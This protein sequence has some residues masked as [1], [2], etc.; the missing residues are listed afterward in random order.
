MIVHEK[1]RQLSWVLLTLLS[2]YRRH[3]GQTAFMTIGLLTGVALWSSVQLINDHARASYGEADQL[4]GAESAYWV[5]NPGGEGI[6]VEDY[7]SL[8]L[9]GFTE[10]YPVVESRVLT[11]SGKVIPIV[12]TDLLALPLDAYGSADTASSPLAGSSWLSFIQPA[13]QSWYSAELAERLNIAPGEEVEL[14]NGRKM[15]PAL[16][17]SRSQQG[18]RVFMDIAAA[19]S[20][21]ADE[22]FSYLAVTSLD[23]AKRAKLEAALPSGLKL[24][25]NEQVLDLTQL[26]ESLHTHLTAMGLLSFAVG[27]FIVFNA[28]RFSLLARQGTFNTLR[29]M[30]A[31]VHLIGTAI[32]LETIV[33]SLIGTAGGLIAG[34]L[35]SGILLPTVAGTLQSLY[36]AIVESDIEL[37]LRQMFLAWLMT[38]LGLVLALAGPLWSRLKISVIEGRSSSL[39]WQQDKRARN[40]MMWCA[41]PLVVLAIGGYFLIETVVDGFVVLSLILFSSAL[42]LPALIQ[43]VNSLFLNRLSRFNWKLRWAASDAFAQLPQLRVALMALLLTLT[44]NIGVTTLVHSFRDALSNWLEVRLSADIYLQRAP[45]QV[46]MLSSVENMQWLVANHNRSG[47]STRWLNRPA[48]VQG[49]DVN[50]PAILGMQLPEQMPHGFERWTSDTTEPQPVLANEQVKHLGKVALGDIVYLDSAKG[51]FS[52]E[53]VGFFHD[54]GTPYYRFYLPKPI[55]EQRWQSVRSEGLALWV[56]PGKLEAAEQALMDAGAEPGEWIRQADIKRVSLEIFDRTFQITAALNSLTLIVAGV[57]L[58][59]ALLAVHQQRMP[60]YAHWYS[61]GVT[62]RE[63]LRLVG[64]P[65]LLMV[66]VTGM[67][68]IPLGWILSWMLVYKLNVVAFGWTMPLVWSWLPVMQLA[69]ITVMVVISALVIVALQVRRRLPVALKQLGGVGL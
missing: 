53:I 26:T 46:E 50:A 21:L 33:W 60:E 17:Q 27:L 45:P 16:I 5:R 7:I 54:Y 24:V 49:V 67:L 48:R 56:A 19:F 57:A 10:V 34:Y 65:L 43:S 29:E 59:S 22:K 40:L 12:A 63:W 38:L 42:V 66:V 47:V 36:G 55:V 51:Q 11:R 58:L 13:Y 52:Y 61:L 69:L 37:G 2:H 30:G 68:A 44:A 41:V 4:L 18:F 15:P 8:R 23:D 31:S 62:F 3:P 64:F 6:A 35:L 14:S 32:V 25:K 39:M 9:Q 20:V 1:T 28:V